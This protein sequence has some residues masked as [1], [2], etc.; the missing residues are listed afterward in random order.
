VIAGRSHE[1]LIQELAGALRPVRR[2]RPPS[3]RALAWLGVVFAIGAAFAVT[4]DL[5][6]IMRRMEG[7][8]D[9]WLSA[10]GSTLTAVLAAFAAFQLSVPG[11]SRLWAALPWPAVALWLGSSGMGCLRTWLVPDARVP[12]L[13][14]TMECLKFIAGFSVPLSLL[15]LAMLRRARPL[16]P[17]LVAVMAGL[18]AA[19]AAA[20]LL[21][22]VHPFDASV[23]DL[24]VHVLTV[25]AVV[26]AD[27]VFGGRLL[28]RPDAGGQA[29]AR[30]PGEG[31][32]T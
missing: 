2:L 7:A 31:A 10:V 1:E 18:A 24:V 27:G 13:G 26:L 29:S 15:L 5:H 14:D 9:M 8:P 3:L 12:T 20:S 11:R 4:V 6:P 25:G 19:A 28:G 23:A 21:W 30:A 22:F 17:G 32:I 16:Q